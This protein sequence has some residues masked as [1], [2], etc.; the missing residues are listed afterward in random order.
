MFLFLLICFK[1][2]YG[3]L[4]PELEFLNSWNWWQHYFCGKQ[5]IFLAE[6]LQ[7]WINPSLQN[8]SDS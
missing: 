1:A 4:E 5:I 7:N 8:T 3:V 2:Y 6:L